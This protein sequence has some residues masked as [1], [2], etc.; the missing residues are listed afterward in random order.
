M[1]PLTRYDCELDQASDVPGVQLFEKMIS[2]MYLGELV[3]R[4]LLHLH[5][6]GVVF[7]KESLESSHL[8]IPYSFDT[9]YMSE[10]ER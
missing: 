8:A 6:K 5:Q 10:I 2:G 4:I 7:K 1:L 9:A 3:R